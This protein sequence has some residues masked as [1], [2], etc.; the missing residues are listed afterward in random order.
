MNTGYFIFS[1][2]MVEKKIRHGV[3]RF[4][5]LL[6]EH[7]F[8]MHKTGRRIKRQPNA[9]V[10]GKICAGSFSG[11]KYRKENKDKNSWRFIHRRK[12][13]CNRERMGLKL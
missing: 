5:C 3:K 10:S 2:F 4:S 7:D 12:H 6:R 13:F 9:A 8:L 11:R 1:K